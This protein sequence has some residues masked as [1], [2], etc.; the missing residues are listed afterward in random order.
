[1]CNVHKI[2]F[3]INKECIAHSA[4]VQAT[5]YIEFYKKKNSSSATAATAATAK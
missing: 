5:S 3:A 2:E 1:M 4:F